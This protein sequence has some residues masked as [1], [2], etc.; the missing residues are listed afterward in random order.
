MKK[1]TT[2]RLEILAEL[3]LKNDQRTFYCDRELIS[4]FYKKCCT[5]RTQSMVV[6]LEK[7][8][9]GI[10]FVNEKKPLISLH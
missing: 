8:Q 10:I 9:P 6:L 4:H 1:F 2:W 5:E 3:S 7:E